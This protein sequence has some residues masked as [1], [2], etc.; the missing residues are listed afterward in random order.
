MAPEINENQPY[1]GDKVDLYSAG[2]VLFIMLYQNPPFG[3]SHSTD[4]MF[5]A[6]SDP[7]KAE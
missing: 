1:E 6:F 2:V 4:G 7:E 5:N 3:K